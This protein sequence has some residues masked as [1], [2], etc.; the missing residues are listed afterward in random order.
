MLA[1]NEYQ[2]LLENLESNIDLNSDF[3]S[4]KL[5]LETMIQLEEFERVVFKS[6]KFAERIVSLYLDQIKKTFF[7]K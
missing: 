7:Y 6:N 1:K 2:K 5:P 3:L 4:I